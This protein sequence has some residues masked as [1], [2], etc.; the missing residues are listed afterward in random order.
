[1]GSLGPVARVLSVPQIL[2]KSGYPG[3]PTAQSAGCLLPADLATCSCHWEILIEGAS[4]DAEALSDL[5]YGEGASIEH[6]LAHGHVGL[7][8]LIWPS[9]LATA[10]KGRFQ[11]LHSALAVEIEE[12]LRDRAEEV[13]HQATGRGFCV[14]LLGQRAQLDPTLLQQVGGIEHFSQGTAEAIDLPDYEL[15]LGTQI[16]KGGLERRPLGT[17]ATRYLPRIPF[18]SPRGNASF[19]RLKY[20]YFYGKHPK[21]YM[22]L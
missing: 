5:G 22:L 6:G 15:I 3:I 8:Q 2:P 4:A 21:A 17:G 13:E 9:A 20:W 1:M 16:G 19:S 12:V 11:A 10:N 7:G 14:Y 18:L